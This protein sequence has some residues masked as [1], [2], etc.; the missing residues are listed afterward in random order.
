MGIFNAGKHLK[1]EKRKYFPKFRSD[2]GFKVPLWF[3]NCHLCWNVIWNFAYSPF[4]TIFWQAIFLKGKTVGSAEMSLGPAVCVM[5]ALLQRSQV[6]ALM[7]L[8]QH[9]QVS[10]VL[11]LLKGQSFWFWPLSFKFLFC[12]D[13]KLILNFIL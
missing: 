1:L 11:V 3:R 12:S 9:A 7:D 4:I 13:L 8:N 2:K 5:M 10:T 6:P